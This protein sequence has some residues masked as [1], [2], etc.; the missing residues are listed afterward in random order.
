MNDQKNEK[1]G[2]GSPAC[3]L[4][5][6]TFVDRVLGFGGCSNNTLFVL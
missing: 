2:D 5:L 3:G 4:W 1:T 6:W